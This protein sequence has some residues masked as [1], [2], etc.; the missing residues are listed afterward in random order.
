LKPQAPAVQVATA[1]T[2]AGQSFWHAPQ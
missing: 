2:G 1:D